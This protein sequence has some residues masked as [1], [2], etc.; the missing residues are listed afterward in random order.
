MA[1]RMVI[2]I[3]VFIQ[4]GNGFASRDG[5]TALRWV[6]VETRKSIDLLL[7]SHEAHRVRC[8]CMSPS[9]LKANWHFLK[10]NL[11]QKYGQLTD[12]DLIFVE[13]KGEELLARLQARLNLTPD[14]LDVLLDSYVPETGAVEKIKAEAGAVVDSLK[15]TA[16]S[17]AEDA[18][19]QVDAAYQQ[20]REKAS[21]AY[22]GAEEG[23][24]RNPRQ[25]LVTAF[26]AG[27][28]VGNLLFRR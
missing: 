23:V 24:R 2:N 16:A 18:K 10:G 8:L 13:G 9:I 27:F 12:D 6:L 1:P 26:L 28:V 20:V 17:L 19:T 5:R 14:K 4:A 15:G 7:S 21:D 22:A 3:T 25:A 11:K